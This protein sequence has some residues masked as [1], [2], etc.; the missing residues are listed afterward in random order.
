MPRLRINVRTIEELDE[1][2]LIDEVAELTEREVCDEQGKG[3]EVKRQ[4]SAINLQRRQEARKFGKDV[5]RIMRQ[6]DNP[7]IPR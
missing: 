4:I 1:L 3:R 6:R 2:D 5:A 7:K